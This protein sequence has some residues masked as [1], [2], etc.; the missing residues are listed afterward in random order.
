MKKFYKS[1]C[2]I[3]IISILLL[4]CKNK[5]PEVVFDNYVEIGDNSYELVGGIIE[6]FGTC[7]D[8]E[9]KYEG[10]NLDLM[11]TTKGL[12]IMSGFGE[13]FIQGEGHVIYFEMYASSPK[14]L[15]DGK[16]EYSLSPPIPIR[17]FDYAD[18]I[19]DYNIDDEY[20][21]EGVEIVD[22]KVYVMKDEDEYEIT[23]MC[24]DKND[25]KIK[26][27]YKGTLSYVDSSEEEMYMSSK[28]KKKN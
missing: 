23:F 1:I 21:E 11:L 13:Y 19:L 2:L 5:V 15:D 17:S 7:I 9:Y 20:Y 10:N 27:Y 25:V 28:S 26:G 6:N 12:H 18:Y 16:Y 24:I 8:E 3:S 22:G 4:G 14:V